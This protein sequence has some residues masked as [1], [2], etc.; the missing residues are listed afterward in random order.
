MPTSNIAGLSWPGATFSA[1]KA[2]GQSG[3]V[4][5]ALRKA[6]ARENCA[7]AGDDKVRG[8]ERVPRRPATRQ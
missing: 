4:R 1:R 8:H 5:H 7:S 6:W 2:R 3:T